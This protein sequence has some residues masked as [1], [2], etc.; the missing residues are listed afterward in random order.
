ME[1]QS[2]Y[3]Y[4]LW[5]LWCLALFAHHPTVR[6]TPFAAGRYRA[7]FYLLCGIPLHKHNTF[8]HS[9]ISGHV[10]N[11]QFH[12][13]HHKY[14]LSL[15]MIILEINKWSP[16]AVFRKWNMQKYFTKD[17]LIS[18]WSFSWYI[19]MMTFFKHV[20][21]PRSRR[22]YKQSHGLVWG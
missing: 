1:L 20:Y 22:E 9:S 2:M 14:H 4:T 13:F 6:F 11:F 15:K 21:F 19:A 5:T 3:N 17:E 16:H 10:G 12:I 7:S 18:F 8:I